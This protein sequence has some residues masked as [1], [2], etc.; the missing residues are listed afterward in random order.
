[1]CNLWHKRI[2][3]IGASTETKL[4][5]YTVILKKAVRDFNS[6]VCGYQIRL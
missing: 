2:K 3:Y 1:M 4:P 5:L 6:S